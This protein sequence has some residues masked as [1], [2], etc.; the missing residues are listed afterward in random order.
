MDVENWPAD[1]ARGHDRQL[2]KAVEV[3]MQQLKDHPVTR[4]TTEPPYPTWGERR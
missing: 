2:E 3:A 4:M 1:L